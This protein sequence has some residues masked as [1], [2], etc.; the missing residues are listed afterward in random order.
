MNAVLRE[1]LLKGVFLGLWAYLALTLPPADAFGR[2]LAWGAGGLVL[3]LTVG[4]MVQV[5]RGYR[6]GRNLAGFALL[7]LLDSPYVIYLGL[8]GGFAVGTFVETDA[9]DGREWLL[10]AVAGGAVLGYGLSQLRL[11]PDRVWRTTLGLIVGGL[12]TYLAVEF[13]PGVPALASA[14]SQWQ[15]AVYLLAG[16]PFFYLLTFCGEAEESEAEVAALFAVLGAGLYLMRLKSSLP[17]QFDKVIFIVPL[18][19][20]IVYATRILQPLKVFKHTLRGYGNLSLGRTRAALVSFAR[21]LHLDRRNKL[22]A[23]GMWQLMRTA[24]VSALDDA[25]ARLLP[26]EFCLDIAAD[27]LMAKVP[28]PAE[29]AEAVRMLGVVERQRPDFAPRADYLRAVADAHAGDFDAAAATLSR[30]LDPATPYP[31]AA[32]EA[33]RTSTLYQAWA[34]ALKQ[35]PA[36]RERLGPAELAKPGRRVDALRAVE[37]H[38]TAQPEDPTGVELKRELY[39]T[40]T[41]AEFTAAAASRVPA[42]LNYDYLEQMGQS[43]VA[44][45]DPGQIDRGMSYLRMAGRGLPGRGPA[46]FT[47]LADIATKLGRAEEAEGYLGQVKRAGLAAGAANLPADQKALYLAALQSLAAS[48]AGRGD[49]PAAVDDYR[50]YV[51]SG[52][53]DADTLRKLAELYARAGDPLNAL[54]IAERGLLYA[55]A[56]PDLLAKKDSYYYSVPVERVAAVRQQVAPWFDIAHCVKRA[57]QVADQAD[58]DPD[59]LDYG[60]HLAKLARTVRPDS[61]AAMLAHGR[62]LIRMGEMDAGTSVLEDLREQPRGSGDDEDAWFQATKILGDRYL[63][64]LGRPDLAA[65]CYSDY[66]DYQRSGA[67]T[68]YHLGRAHEAA[69]NKGAARK[70]FELVTAYQN[71]PRYWDATEAVRR[72]SE[73]RP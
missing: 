2:V 71:H 23:D 35:H 34:L 56:D 24:D 72:L 70:A 36:L 1:Y 49:I 60:L 9:P 53:E 31:G 20:Y 58:A 21:A 5:R 17:G 25:T 73:P 68:L 65:A 47:Q 30:L 67:D 29:R 37:R 10:Y 43:L 14:Q 16:L 27:L 52:K 40:L 44:D 11:V 64:E 61:Q 18:G 69:G 62:L 32:A 45:P 38:L 59:T 22:A 6:P 7:V 3:A 55:K 50:L 19:L 51:E 26:V 33:A 42:E 13:V 66:R 12:L 39:S 28:T 54:L 46:I 57:R 48:A 63:D 41:E 8:V 15:F 4:A